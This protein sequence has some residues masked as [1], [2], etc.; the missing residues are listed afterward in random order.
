MRLKEW[1]VRRGLKFVYKRGVNLLGRYGLKSSKATG[2]ILVCLGTLANMGCLPTFPTPGIIVQRNTRFFQGLQAEGAEIAV[3]SYTHVD[4]NSLT[5]AEAKGQITRA[6]QTFKHN[7]IEAAWFSLPV[8][9]L[10]G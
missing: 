5:L 3:H 1:Y 10:F 7:G 9:E 6:V 4:L 2:Q 8:P